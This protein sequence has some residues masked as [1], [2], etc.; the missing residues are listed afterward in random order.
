MVPQDSNVCL[1]SRELNLPPV[2]MWLRSKSWPEPGK[3]R[4]VVTLCLPLQCLLFYFASQSGRIDGVAVFIP[5]MSAPNTHT[6]TLAHSPSLPVSLSPPLSRGKH[7]LQKSWRRACFNNL[8]VS[9]SKPAVVTPASLC[10]GGHCVCVWP[11]V[12]VCYNSMASPW[13]IYTS[14]CTFNN[15]ITVPVS[16]PR[17]SVSL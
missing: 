6:H 17:L 11:C 2:M 14:P 10:V 4:L 1:R 16:P 9:K 7:I 15:S 3:Y 5:A 12:C 13:Q 8:K